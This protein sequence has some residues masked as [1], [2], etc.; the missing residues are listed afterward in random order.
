MEWGGGGEGGAAAGVISELPAYAR[1]GHGWLK[2]G[3]TR[4]WLSLGWLKLAA[5][6]ASCLG[7]A[8]VW[9]PDMK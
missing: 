5:L 3:E 4:A 6:I 8:R 9:I 7:E 1:R 2:L